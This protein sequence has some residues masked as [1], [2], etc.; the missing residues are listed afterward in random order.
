MVI[1]KSIILFLLVICFQLFVHANITLPSLVGDHMILQ[2]N[3][4]VQLWGWASPGEQITINLGWQ[5]KDIETTADEEGNWKVVIQTP[6]TD[7]TPYNIILKGKNTINIQ[8]VLL[9]EVWLCSGQSNMFFPVG[10]QE[11][12]WKTGVKNF[13]EEVENADYPNIRLFTVGLNVSQTP[14]MDVEGYWKVCSPET[15][16]NFSAVAY[17]FGRNLQND[18]NVPIGLI[19]SS[20]GGTRAEAW[21]S[22][23]VLE[24]NPDF[25]PILNRYAE[26]EKKYYQGLADYYSELQNQENNSIVSSE[27]SELKKP[28]KSEMN[29]DPYVLYNAMLH[30]L[31]NYTIKGAIWYQGESNAERA[32]QYRS[33]FPA[34][35][36]N[37]RSDWQEGNF[38]FYFVQIAPHHSQNPEI[39]EAQLMAFNSVKNTGLVVT[40]D[41]GN[42]KNIHPIDKQT[43]GKRLSLWARAK[44]YGEENLVFSGPIYSHMEIKKRSVQVYFDHLG[45]GLQNK[46]EELAEFEIAGSDQKFY[47]AKAKIKGKTIV[48]SSQKVKNPIAVRFAWKT[49]P[50]PNLFNKEGLPASPFRTD[51]WPGETYNKF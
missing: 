9:G 37:W 24:E 6:K 25:V 16:N 23:E 43:V 33:L 26:K 46:K 49:S 32:Y 44:T 19:S 30:P 12:T 34:M 35:I 20:W 8:D 18:L 13:K 48:V 36:K 22:Q 14:L 47:P 29:K 45:S 51:D 15:I 10:K 5:Q 28:S 4:N 2:Q 11:G 50:E 1:K 41:V 42:P 31:I 17:F 21:T 39:R 40:T 27:K 38:P 7:Q 3:T